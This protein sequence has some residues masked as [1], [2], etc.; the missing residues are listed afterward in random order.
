MPIIVVFMTPS[1]QSEDVPV[2][3]SSEESLEEED[4]PAF[5]RQDP[6]CRFTCLHVHHL[7]GHEENIPGT[8]STKKTS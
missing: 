3:S 2:E 5:W 4:E 8:N 7:T 1:V 6:P